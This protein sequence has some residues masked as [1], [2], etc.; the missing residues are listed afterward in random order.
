MRW[1]WPPSGLLKVENIAGFA[2]YTGTTFHSGSG[3]AGLYVVRY[4]DFL[5]KKTSAISHQ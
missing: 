5:K 4:I 3:N 2:P 1:R